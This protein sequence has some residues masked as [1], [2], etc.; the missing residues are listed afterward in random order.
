MTTKDDDII[1]Q[2]E[3]ANAAYDDALLTEFERVS[4]GLTA[5]LDRVTKSGVLPRVKAVLEKHRLSDAVF[6]PLVGESNRGYPVGLRLDGSLALQS[7]QRKSVTIEDAAKVLTSSVEARF[8]VD[9]DEIDGCVERYLAGALKLVE[10]DTKRL[11]AK[12]QRNGNWTAP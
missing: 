6:M 2:F 12:G 1:K 9:Q 11:V 3:S 7:D 4:K 10:R 8:P 5:F